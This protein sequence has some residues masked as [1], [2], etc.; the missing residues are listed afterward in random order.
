[1]K[2]ILILGAGRSSSSLIRY[3]LDAAV[4]NDFTITVADTSI[5]A[6]KLKTGNHPRSSAVALDIVNDT[7]TRSEISKA[8]IVI[9]M[10][11]AFLHPRIA[12]QCV[13]LKKSMVTASYVSAEMKALDNE[14]QKAGV[15]LMNESGLDPGIDH[16][17]AMAVI[18]RVKDSGGKIVSF[19]S[20]TG[21]L[22]AP[23]SDDNPW[24]YKFTW[25]PRNVVLAG[26]GTARYIENGKYTYI[27]YHKLFTRIEKLKIEGLGDF[28]GYANRDSLSYRNIYE[29]EDVSTMIRGTL[30]KPGYCEAWN[31]FVQLGITD[32]SYTVTDSG[33]MTYRQFID[34]FLPRGK[35]SI[36]ERLAAYVNTPA[37]GNI[38]KMLRWTGI[39]EESA[40]ILKDATPAQILQAL[41]EEKWKLNENDR[42]MIVMQHQFEYSHPAQKQIKSLKT[43]LVVK[44]DDAVHT[45]MAKTVGLPMGIVTK[46]ILN[47]VIKQKGVCIP[48]VGE[49]Y[50]PLL[51]EL[52]LS[53]IRF[54]ET[55]E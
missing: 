6:V 24:Q 42:D 33:R 4:K 41:L 21:G 31:V 43:S 1:M 34:S 7:L 8:D 28:E 30:R 37:K 27:P 29:I 9:S 36:E 46:L 16:A 48:T 52:E 40:V 12:Q 54:E 26:Q 10:L 22:I 2:K 11:P 5:E 3:L 15:I 35:G 23:E 14:A 13:A 39:F 45:A 19:K 55:Q 51:K 53:G 50:T 44:G 32:D 25:N 49:I 17:S 20:Y 47:G 38:M 18:D